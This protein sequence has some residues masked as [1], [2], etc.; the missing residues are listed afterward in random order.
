MKGGR[1][2]AVRGG[3]SGLPQPHDGINKMITNFNRMGF[4][5]EDMIAL[6]ACGHTLGG[7]HHADFPE[8]VDRNGDPAKPWLGSDSDRIHPFDRSPHATD[9]DAVPF[10]NRV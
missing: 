9:N 8:H 2:D 10:D 7:V 5:K 1:V 4:N 6:V 3:P